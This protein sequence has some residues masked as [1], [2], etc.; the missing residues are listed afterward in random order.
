MCCVYDDSIHLY[1]APISAYFVDYSET[2]PLPLLTKHSSYALIQ[3]SH[4]LFSRAQ[5]VH[6][7]PVYLSN[8]FVSLT[9]SRA[10]LSHLNFQAPF[11]VSKLLLFPDK[12]FFHISQPVPVRC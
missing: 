10:I 4:S 2:A 11:Q 12:S 7:T 5:T 9:S 1:A 6:L 3:G 8:W